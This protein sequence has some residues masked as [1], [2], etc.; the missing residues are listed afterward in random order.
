MLTRPGT[1]RSPASRYARGTAE[2][3]ETAA[4]PGRRKKPELR[5]APVAIAYVSNRPSSF[6]SFCFF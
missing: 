3:T 1:I 6:L 5:V 2:P 4:S